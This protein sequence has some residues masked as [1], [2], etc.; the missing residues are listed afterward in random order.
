[1]LTPL[2]SMLAGYRPGPRV[3]AACG[4]ALAGTLLV[5][6]DETEAVAAAVDGVAAA[7]FELGG[8]GFI[9][10]SAVFY[11]MGVV[12][13]A[14]YAGSLPPARIATSKSFVL[15]GLGLGSLAVVSAS[16]LAQGQPL[17]A[18][19]GGVATD[20]VCWAAL[21]WSGLG[22][23]ALASYLHAQASR[24]RGPELKP[25]GTAALLCWRGVESEL[26]EPGL[27]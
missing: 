27:P 10:L 20:P 19:W 17:S 25:C 9:I 12:R 21:L 5:T 7:G 11:S 16:T 15:G 14:G 26:I 8:D 6:A 2:F 22:P 4:L 1:M 3:W 24:C 18:M 13:L 23:G